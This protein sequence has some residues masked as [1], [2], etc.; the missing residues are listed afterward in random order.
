[1]GARLDI[2]IPGDKLA[3][4]YQKVQREAVKLRTENQRLQGQLEKMATATRS[5]GAS[6]GESLQAIRDPL[7]R[8]QAGLAQASKALES[9]KINQEQYRNEVQRLRTQFEGSASPLEKYTQKLADAQENLRRGKITGETY[10]RTLR[11]LRTEFAGSTT[12]AE[13]YKAQVAALQEAKRKGTITTA[14]YK[15][16]LKEAGAE[17]K[18]LFGSAPAG[19]ASITQALGSLVGGSLSVGAIVAQ[20]RAALEEA[21]QLREDVLRKQMT[22]GEAQ[23]ET[24]KMLGTVST[25]EASQFLES[26]ERIGKEA[27]F[28]DTAMLYL[29]AADTL[30]ATASDQQLT[31]AILKQAAPL[32]KNRPQQIKEFAGAVADLAKIEGSTSE[33]AIKGTVSEVLSITSQARI[34]SLAAFTEAAGRAVREAG[35]AFAA[36]GGSIKDPEG[37]LTKTAT[38][39]LATQLERLLPEKDILGPVSEQRRAELLREKAQLEEKLSA[40]QAGGG[41]ATRATQ[42]A[43]LQADADW[44]RQLEAKATA[45]GAESRDPKVQEAQRVLA[46]RHGARAT[47]LE[48]QLQQTRDTMPAAAAADAAEAELARKRLEQIDLQMQGVIRKGTGKKTLAERISTVQDSPELQRLFFEGDTQQGIGEASFRGPIEPVIRTLLTSR[49]SEASQRFNTA[50]GAISNDPAS[51]NQLVQ[52]LQQASPQLQLQENVRTAQAITES[53]D[54]GATLS[55]A[56]AAVEQKAQ[57]ALL[58]TR[59]GFGII[60]RMAESVERNLRPTRDDRANMENEIAQLLVRRERIA[61]GG[62][63]GRGISREIPVLENMRGQKL[64]ETA[65]IAGTPEDRKRLESL[66]EQ[67]RKQVEYLDQVVQTLLRI[68]DAN[69]EL[70]DAVTKGP[71]VGASAAA[72]VPSSQRL[73]R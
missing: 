30:S 41:D 64:L 37:A 11:E 6:L 52:N 29:A 33:E 22:V 44:A 14:E 17:T 21:K 7:M 34:T 19:L 45:T 23:G 18:D 16:A 51:Y 55:A 9:G 47:Q 15:K 56:R 36:I 39:M 28:Q 53:R 46:Q 62:T 57:E 12:A 54:Q 10:E 43:K 5:T 63:V 69:G 73:S 42:M 25:P 72:A 58:R 20:I 3:A 8:L 66:D 61:G 68:A 40:F 4:E 27:G 48:Q 13:R 26:V 2:E 49:E 32:F 60:D 65:A 35:A 1:M 38:S 59:Q 70:R 31:L 67:A 24:V 50:R 71:A